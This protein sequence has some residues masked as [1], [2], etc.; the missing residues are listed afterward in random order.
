MWKFHS[1]SLE[2]ICKTFVYF[3][4]IR[5]LYNPT[6]NT[7]STWV[8]HNFTDYTDEDVQKVWDNYL[9]YYDC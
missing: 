3:L 8:K 5:F 2:G 7:C 4:K 9:T 1:C 6:Y